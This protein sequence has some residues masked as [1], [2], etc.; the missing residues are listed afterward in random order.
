MKVDFMKAGARI[1]GALGAGYWA[2]MPAKSAEDMNSR[3]KMMGLAGVLAILAADRVGNSHARSALVTFGAGCVALYGTGTFSAV[4]QGAAAAK[5][6]Q[7][8]FFGA[9]WTGAQAD[10]AGIMGGSK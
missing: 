4:A 7:P 2:T 10:L 6:P 8:S 3:R 1:G 5:Q 9:L